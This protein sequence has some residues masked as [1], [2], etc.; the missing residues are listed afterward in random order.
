MVW[1]MTSHGLA[2][3]LSFYEGKPPILNHYFEGEHRCYTILVRISTRE[4]PKLPSNGLFLPLR[5]LNL[6]PKG[7]E[8]ITIDPFS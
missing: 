6:F 2:N 5:L 7:Y 3:D 4:T 8:T 1:P